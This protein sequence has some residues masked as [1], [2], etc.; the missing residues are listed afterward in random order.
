LLAVSLGKTT[1]W[2]YTCHRNS[3][4]QT[5]YGMQVAFVHRQWRI[6]LSVTVK[7]TLSGKITAA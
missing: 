1:H 5:Q 6:F 3:G 2:F 4:W 7:S